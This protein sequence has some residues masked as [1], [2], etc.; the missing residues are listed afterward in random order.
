MIGRCGGYKRY[1]RPSLTF[2][3]NRFA[4]NTSISLLKRHAQ[5]S[6][7]AMMRCWEMMTPYTLVSRKTTLLC[8]LHLLTKS[9]PQKML[10]TMAYFNDSWHNTNIY[11]AH[12]YMFLQPLETLSCDCDYAKASQRDRLVL[13]LFPPSVPLILSSSLLMLSFFS[14][15][16]S[17]PPLIRWTLSILLLQI[18]PFA[19]PLLLSVQTWLS[20]LTVLLD[21]RKLCQPI[22]MQHSSQELNFF[23]SSVEPH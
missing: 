22:F 21:R 1:S 7:L 10:E 14:H 5:V 17:L 20:S 11:L 16:L 23:L 12:R 4:S 9:D 2:L 3:S 18:Y 19:P 15:P 8:F 6:R 13:L